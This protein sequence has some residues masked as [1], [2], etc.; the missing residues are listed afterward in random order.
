MAVEIRILTPDEWP[1]VE[2]IVTS[3]FQDA[4]PHSSA[5]SSFVAGLDGARLAGFVQIEQLFHAN[6][7]YVAPE[8][9]RGRVA[10]QMMKEVARLI[11]SGHS[12]IVLTDEPG[13]QRLVEKLGMRDAG[14]WRL[15]RK[16]F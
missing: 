1:L 16:D 2:P 7:L 4:L 13:V 10:W 9:R 14:E 6:C 5:Q 12:V 3:V 11:P 8:Y 15:L